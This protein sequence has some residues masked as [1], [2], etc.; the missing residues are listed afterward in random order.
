MVPS[1]AQHECVVA[2]CGGGELVVVD[3]LLN[4]VVYRSANVVCCVM[5]MCIVY[6]VCVLYICITLPPIHA[7]YKH[8]NSPPL[9][10]SLSHTH[11]QTHTHTHTYPPS[12]S[13][14]NANPS[15][16]PTRLSVGQN[17]QLPPAHP[18][19]TKNRCTRLTSC[20]YTAQSVIHRKP[21]E[22]REGV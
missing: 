16:A 5:C 21:A 15:L 19:S 14:A 6:C 11:T 20:S 2:V 8:T 22:A 3:V 4:D 10:L 9:S 17:T 13:P 1:N 18:V 12:S 7:P